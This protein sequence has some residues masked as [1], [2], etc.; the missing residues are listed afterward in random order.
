MYEVTLDTLAKK[1]LKKLDKENQKRIIKKLKT[2][3]KNP[4]AG[5]FLVGNLSGLYKLRIGNY[6]AIYKIFQDKLIVII[7]NIGHR[8]N[9]YY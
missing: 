7:L 5:K 1:F 6:R 9:I 8:K 3:S 4:R 2:L